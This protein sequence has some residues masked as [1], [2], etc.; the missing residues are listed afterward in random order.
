MNIN[1]HHSD[2]KSH[3]KS[4]LLNNNLQR[5]H[6]TNN[7]QRNNNFGNWEFF[8]EKNDWFHCFY[9]ECVCLT[10]KAV[11]KP[12]S[13]GQ[14]AV[15]TVCEETPHSKLQTNNSSIGQELHCHI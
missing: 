15:R 2:T 5:E 6:V 3:Q 10:S 7:E 8:S 13:P 9:Y 14:I 12:Q 11:F 1:I 4:F